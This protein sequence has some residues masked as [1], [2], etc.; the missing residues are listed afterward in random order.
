MF[1]TLH[2]I[3]TSSFF[4]PFEDFEDS[5]VRRYDDRLLEEDNEEEQDE[6]REED[7]FLRELS[8]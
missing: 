5:T 8:L 1:T 6:E 4:D 2:F 3:I 7:F